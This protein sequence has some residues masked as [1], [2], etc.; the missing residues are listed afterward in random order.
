M[1]ATPSSPDLSS[2]PHALR[3]LDDLGFYRAAYGGTE[4]MAK[5][6]SEL[7]MDGVLAPDR[8]GRVAVA[9]YSADPKP[10]A[11]VDRARRGARLFLHHGFFLFVPTG[12]PRITGRLSPD[13]GV[14]LGHQQDGRWFLHPTLFTTRSLS[15]RT[16]TQV[17]K[18]FAL[19]PPAPVAAGRVDPRRPLWS[20]PS[21]PGVEEPLP[22][23][24]LATLSSLL[25]GAIV[26]TARHEGVVDSPFTG[27][28]FNM[29]SREGPRLG[30]SIFRTA[31]GNVR[32]T[33]QE[34]R[35]KAVIDR[36]MAH[37]HLPARMAD[38]H[39]AIGY[40]TLCTVALRESSAHR[41]FESLA[42]FQARCAEMGLPPLARAA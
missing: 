30:A 15:Q 35:L 14:A 22:A 7:W 18:A 23:D 25:L 41:R 3:P 24:V 1:T 8:Q 12:V 36:M 16:A 42:L 34:A 19:H 9:P 6:L 33:T 32:C 40:E 5:L 27:K 10:D 17:P 11:L 26:E 38:S 39:P 37:G 28:V 2:S 13:I 20:L 4:R 29:P 21:V 31:Q